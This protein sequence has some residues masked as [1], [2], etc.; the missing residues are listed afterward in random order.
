VCRGTPVA[1]HW[2]IASNDRIINELGRIW[3]EVVVAQ[4]EEL[5]RHL[6]EGTV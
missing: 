4:F 1:H 3:K 2:P 6:L 5:S